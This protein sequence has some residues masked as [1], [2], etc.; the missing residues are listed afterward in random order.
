MSRTL[1]T[2]DVIINLAYNPKTLKIPQS[3]SFREVSTPLVVSDG[4]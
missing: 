4:T 1:L 3:Y 2:L